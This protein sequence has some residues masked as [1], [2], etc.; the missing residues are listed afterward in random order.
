[1]RHLSSTGRNRKGGASHEQLFILMDVN[2]RTGLRGGG[3]FMNAHCGM[4]GAY[5]RNTRNDN[6]ERLLAF[7][8]S[9]HLALVNLFFQYPP[10]RN[11]AYL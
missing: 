2:A 11:L 10:K 9:N 5:G 7:A 6:V 3:S 1:M 8:F 4:L